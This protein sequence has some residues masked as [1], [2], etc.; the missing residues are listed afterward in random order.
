M[1]TATALPEA[2]LPTRRPLSP[3][4]LLLGGAALIFMTFMRFGVAELGWLV[5]APYLVFLHERAT[6]RRHLALLAALAAAFLLAVSKMATSEIPW[7]P[8]PMFALPLA[9][10]YFL[11]L[12]LAGAAHRRLGARYG[13][14]TFASM[15][16]VMGW[17]QYSFTE[18]S[19]WGVLAHT[20]VDNL[21]L[22]QVAALTGIGGITFLVALGSGLLA[23]AWSCGVRAVRTDLI[24]FGL[25]LGV[26]LVYGQLR[27]AQPAPGAPVR[28]GGVVSPVTAQEFR[29]AVGNIDT[30]RSLDDELFARSGRAAD[31]GAQVVVWNEIATLTSVAGESALV[32]RGQAFAKVREVLLVMAYGV[33]NDVGPFHY[34][35]KYR[36]YL[37]DGTLAE[38]LPAHCM[39]Q[40]A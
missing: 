40:H 28:I 9:L 38:R 10:S 21:P 34:A 4:L 32:S 25:L 15:A 16:V 26:A 1:T 29:G 2:G 30:L 19:S 8:V 27:L 20:Q 35:N 23:A 14:Y 18:G 17:V 13:I 7:M 24:V 22:V 37:P 36:I 39:G 12:A 3:A 33:V 31:L 6:L 11:V 5:F